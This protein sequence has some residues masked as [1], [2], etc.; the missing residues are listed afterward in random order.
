[1][2]T[3]VA[4]G[5]ISGPQAC[6]EI[7]QVLGSWFGQFGQ[8]RGIQRGQRCVCVLRRCSKDCSH[9][10]GWGACTT[11]PRLREIV[12]ASYALGA[13]YCEA[14]RHPLIHGL[15][16]KEPLGY[17]SCLAQ[18]TAANHHLEEIR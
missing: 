12:R 7:K 2:G 18:T 16:A 5:S 15:T 17:S 14:F 13:P 8:G 9:E 4:G 11:T 6:S 3:R 1:M 10:T